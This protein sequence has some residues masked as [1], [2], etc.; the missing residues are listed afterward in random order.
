MNHKK[1]F[2]IFSFIITFPFITSCSNSSNGQDNKT[3]IIISSDVA[4]GLVNG[5]SGG[6]S[7]T[8]DSYAVEL[9]SSYIGC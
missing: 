7:D 2:L 3:K 9:M 1:L 5:K 6:P 4:A 8:D